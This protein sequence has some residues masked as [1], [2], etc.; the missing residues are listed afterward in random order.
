MDEV[1]QFLE[2]A[3]TLLSEAN[4]WTRKQT[5]GQEKTKTAIVR[6]P[7][8]NNKTLAKF[9][10]LYPFFD[11]DANDGLLLAKAG[12]SPT[13]LKLSNAAQRL[14]GYQGKLAVNKDAFNEYWVMRKGIQVIVRT[15]R[16]CA[17]SGFKSNELAEALRFLSKKFEV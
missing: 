15:L 5:G 4:G 17:N 12:K 16:R 7:A 10:K 14:G 3:K 8:P 6:A 1:Q 13:L 9:Y 11:L 2:R